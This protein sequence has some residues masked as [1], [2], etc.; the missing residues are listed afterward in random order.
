MKH[1]GQFN[2]RL[3]IAGAGLGDVAMARYNLC[4]AELYQR[5]LE[6]REG[7]VATGGALAV[8]TGAHTGRSASDKYYVRDDVTAET[9]WWDNVQAMTPAHFAALHADMCAHCD[10]ME[11]YVQDLYG[12]ADE[13]HRIKV[14]VI[15]QFAWHALFIRHLLRRPA[16]AELDSFEPQLTIIDIPGFAA[17]PAR[18]GTRS[19]TVIA[20]DLTG[21]LILIGGTEYAGEIKKSVFGTLNYFLPDKG[22]MPMH[23]SANAGADGTSALFF[24]LSGTGKTT[25]SSDAGRTLV[26]DDEHGWSPNGIFNFEGGCYAKTINLSREAE[27][28][29]HATTRRWGSVLENVVIDPDTRI[30]DF[31]DDS[32][33]ENGRVA[34]PIHYIDNA[35]PTGT[36]AHPSNVIMLTADASGVLPP[37]A[38]LSPEQ[39]MYHFLSGYT[40]KVAGTEKGVKGT[41]AT[42][43][44]CFGAP[45]MPRHPGVYGDLLRQMMARHGT[46]CW[47]VNTGWTAGPYG[48]GHRM[49]IR[50]TRALLN[51]ALDASLSRAQMRTD[52]W[53]GFEV[54]VGVPGIKEEILDPRR[55]WPDGAAY[56]RAAAALAASFNDNFKRFAGHVSAAVRAAGPKI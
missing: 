4:E 56:D 1:T 23:C 40:A 22:V 13:D 30:A 10:G 8:T 36:A 7:I 41:Q 26:G 34:Y 3:T 48:Q 33:T 37:I 11:V 15:T 47:L 52:P 18:H 2:H 44:A 12:G 5:A 6:A 55:T 31:D 32:L 39:A 38:R 50:V 17:G 42:F 24:G 20:G 53:F 25:L 49:P 29:I 35:S 16:R 46:V 54:P 43:S 45:F 14:R 9:I 21:G 51:A 27:P 19:Q 28:E